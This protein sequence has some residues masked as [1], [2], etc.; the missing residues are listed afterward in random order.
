M[1]VWLSLVVPAEEWFIPVSRTGK[2]KLGMARASMESQSSRSRVRS[3]AADQAFS[4]EGII[5]SLYLYLPGPRLHLVMV[6]HL[7]YVCACP[8]SLE[9]A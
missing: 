7:I 8:L 6:I 2:K 4:N 3:T 9:P 1:T 5:V